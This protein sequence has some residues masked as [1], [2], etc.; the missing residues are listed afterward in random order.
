[1][2]ARQKFRSALSTLAPGEWPSYLAARSGLPGPRA[3]LELAQ[4]AADAATAT[5]IAELAASPDEFLALCGAI[6]LGRLVSENSDERAE[7]E[8]RML[9]DDSR[10]RVREGVAMALQRVGAANRERLW[11]LAER[12]V[13]V[14]AQAGPDLL[15]LRAVAAGV[16]EPRLVKATA[17]ASRAVRILD[18]IT[19]IV[20]NVPVP[21]R[22]GREDVRVLRQALGYAWSVAAVGAPE[23]GFDRLERWARSGDPDARWIAR[24]NAGKA[25]LSRVDPQ[26]AAALLRAAQG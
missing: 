3:N 9:A 25:R 26:R 22:R 4:A 23:E 7:G 13:D 1:M 10:W 6:G 17:D 19:E 14:G 5:Q 2:S 18:R 24:S 21:A 12:W 16:A 20:M 11:L 15:L 8:L